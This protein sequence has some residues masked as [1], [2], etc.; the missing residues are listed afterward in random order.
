MSFKELNLHEKVLEALDASGFQTPTPIQAQ[1][2]PIILE[3]ADLVA[4]AQTGTGKTAAFLLPMLSE[5]IQRKVEGVG[6]LVVVPTREL[7]VQIDQFLEGFSYFTAL[8]SIA[9]YG[10]SSGASF[11]QEKIALSQGADLVVA[12]PGKLI[13]HLNMGYA[14]LGNLQYLVLDEA[15]KMLDMG[16]Y[17]DIKRIVSH[18][19][20]ERQ[21]L[22][23]SA[24]MPPKIRKL[25][26]EILQDPQ[27]VN[28]AIAKPA[29]GIS[30]IVYMV[31]DHQKNSLISHILRVHQEM[32]SVIVFSNRK[33]SVRQLEQE[34]QALDISA[35][36]IHSDLEQKEREKILR[37]FKNR[38]VRVLIGTDIIARG[39]DV[40]GI[41]LVINYEVPKNVEDYVHRIG[42][43]ARAESEGF[44]FTFVNERDQRNLHDIQRF[45]GRELTQFDIPPFLGDAPELKPYRAQK[46]RQSGGRG[47]SGKGGS[48]RGNS[49]RPRK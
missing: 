9:M 22:L 13:S 37:N 23:F 2:I 15:D 46:H 17:E 34:L 11:S 38:K 8:S 28:I 20:E 21:T 25:A 48:S 16:F 47:Q 32:K 29:E 40:E 45:L 7:A 31:Y 41:D 5:L 12:T 3:N 36:G 24:T 6:A 19:P 1:A 39:I 42:R 33:D 10:G 44:A 26:D 4:C 49:R 43:T 14:E 30:Q 27:E 18:L 35:V